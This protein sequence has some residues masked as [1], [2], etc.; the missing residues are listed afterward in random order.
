MGQRYSVLVTGK[1]GWRGTIETALLLDVG[2]PLVLVRLENGQQV[3]VPGRIFTPLE[4]GS[5]YVPL[6]SGELIRQADDFALPSDFPYPATPAASVV[7]TVWLY[8]V[9]AQ[10]Q[11]ER[12]NRRSSVTKTVV[13]L[14]DRFAAAQAVVRDLVSDG[15]RRNDIGFVA[16][17]ASGEYRARLL[18][19][20]TGTGE[21]ASG[22]G[23]VAGVAGLLVGLNGFSF[24]GLGPIIAG[25]PLAAAMAGA[26]IGAITGGLVGALRDAG[27][28]EREAHLYAEGVR[29]GGIVIT[30]SLGDDHPERALSIFNRNGALDIEEHA[31]QWRQTGWHER[32]LSQAQDEE[33]DLEDAGPFA[34]E[35]PL[36]GG[37]AV[38]LGPARSDSL[39]NSAALASDVNSA[40]GEQSEAQSDPQ[41]QTGS[42]AGLE[43]ARDLDTLGRDFR[44]HHDLVYGA[45]DGP[46]YERVQSGYFFGYQLATDDRYKDHKWSEIEPEAR[47]QWL[48]AH[49]ADNWDDL[50][51]AIRYGWER[52]IG[53]GHDAPPAAGPSSAG[54]DP[55]SDRPSYQGPGDRRI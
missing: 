5:Y 24:P 32:D 19:E 12:T 17:D 39:Q 25:G 34:P 16:G 45:Q 31:H 1:E 23:I 33:L 47:R 26:G 4:D 10:G 36:P 46:G 42:Q 37:P 28:P 27:V 11:V 14:F 29:R 30:L 50:K 51:D 54:Q 21:G 6:T 41:L 20:M 40:A 18:D 38:S 43:T 8:E 2:E 35:D 7:S 49:S 53:T 9:N 13:A 55:R 3:L 44:R 22:H 52:T 48:Q 15:F